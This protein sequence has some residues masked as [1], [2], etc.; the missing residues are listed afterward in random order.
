MRIKNSLEDECRSLKNQLTDATNPR[1]AGELQSQIAE[2]KLVEAYNHDHDK[3]YGLR[4]NGEF[5]TFNLLMN[6]GFGYTHMAGKILKYV[7]ECFNTW[8][9]KSWSEVIYVTTTGFCI[10]V[11][12]MSLCLSCM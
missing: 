10:I 7:N 4:N 1:Q 3:L 5:L 6:Y 8:E 9:C 2:G 12:C 11:C